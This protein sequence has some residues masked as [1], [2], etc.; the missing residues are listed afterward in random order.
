MQENLK[1]NQGKIRQAVLLFIT[2][3][4]NRRLR[5]EA[6]RLSI[7]VTDLVRAPSISDALTLARGKATT[8]RAP[9][10]GCWTLGGRTSTRR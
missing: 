5:T 8:G 7:G 2:Q 10:T 9:S 4:Q 1:R 3:K 6:A